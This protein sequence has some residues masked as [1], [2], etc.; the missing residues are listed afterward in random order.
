MMCAC[1]LPLH[2]SDPNIQAI[3]QKIV[4]SFGECVIVACGDKSFRVNRHYIALHGLTASEL[5]ELAQKGI[6]EEVK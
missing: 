4:D 3:V 1:G 6:V 2:Y 5:P